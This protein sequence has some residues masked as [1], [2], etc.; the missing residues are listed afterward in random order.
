MTTVTIQ[1]CKFDDLYSKKAIN[2][3]IIL[4]KFFWFSQMN[5]QKRNFEPRMQN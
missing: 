3:K 4:K 2:D 5:T 1:T